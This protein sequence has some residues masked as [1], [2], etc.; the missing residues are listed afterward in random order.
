[1]IRA[2]SPRGRLIAGLLL[3]AAL[4]TGTP[5]FAQTGGTP[6]QPPPTQTDP[7]RHQ[8]GVGMGV[9][10]QVDLGQV[11]RLGR[12]L[13]QS[14]T[15]PAYTPGRALLAIEADSAL[16]PAA[17]AAEAGL[18]LIETQTLTALGLT[19]AELEGE[20]EQLPTQL[21]R[22]RAAHPDLSID[23]APVW[24]PQADAATSAALPG[25]DVGRLYATHLL[26]VSAPQPLPHTVKVALLDGAVDPA[27]G[28]AVSDLQTVRIADGG[29]PDQ[30]GTSVA[31]L[32][33][34]RPRGPTDATFFGP[35]P[36][37]T[38]LNAAVLGRDAQGRAQARALDVLRG[39]DWA[40]QQGAQLLNVSLGAAPDAVTA[41]A[42]ALARPKLAA[43]IAAAGN[44]GATGGPVYPAAL[45]G[46]IAVAA[47][48]ARLR[49]YRQGSQGNWVRVAAPGVELWVPQ[50]GERGGR[51]RSG[52]SFAAPLVTAYLAQRLARDLPVDAAS[53]CAQAR[54]LPPAGPDPQTGCGLLQ[55]PDRF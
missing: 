6:Q 8:G 31:C 41:R 37:I 3:G 28:L 12:R 17:L 19:V 38:L 2:I 24:Y 7:G 43:I 13:L 54:D 34:C 53:L 51:Y 4:L 16:S 45:P 33:A 30:H 44:G 42:F 27:I 11:F 22:L 21:Q 10:V 9:G 5:A 40:L 23:L 39:L 26:G 18:R 29:D 36:G 48:D 50:A 49:P 46:V 35:S 15:P 1:M 32:I 25:Q 14:D 52:T 55:W 47:V 20:P